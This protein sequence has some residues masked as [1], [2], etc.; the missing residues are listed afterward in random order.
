ML[1][2]EIV[3]M[4]LL[5]AIKTSTNS[6]PSHVVLTYNAIKQVN[7]FWEIIMTSKG[8]QFLPNVYVPRVDILP[9]AIQGRIVVNVQRIIR[10]FGPFS[11]LSLELKNIINHPRWNS[12]WIEI[13]VYAYGWYVLENLFWKSR[14]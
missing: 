7:K 6:W 13:V 8:R 4:I 11:G 10:N 14:K 3:E 1:P 5:T 12:A 9:K 2:S